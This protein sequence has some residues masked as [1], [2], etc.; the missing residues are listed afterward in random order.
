MIRI[1][2][3]TSVGSLVKPHGIKGE[4]LAE[5]DYE[6]DLASAR[7]IVLDVDGIFVPFFID[8]LRPRSVS[9]VLIHIDGVDSEISAKKICGKEFY[10]L[11]E[12]MPETDGLDEDGFFLSELVGFKILDADNSEIGEIVDYDDSTEN[13][14]FMVRP[15]TGESDQ[16]IYIPVADDFIR[17]L[18]SQA[19]TIT[20]D[21]PSGLIDL[22]V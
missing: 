6:F 8:G 13:S 1:E 21:L 19:G 20:M 7:C 12:D 2:E 4:I 10:V 5:V 11:N 22:N 9:S 14:L 3:I 18:D 17:S 16:I 15:A